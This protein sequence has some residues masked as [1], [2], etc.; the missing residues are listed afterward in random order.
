MSKLL[1]SI[2]RKSMG[3]MAIRVGFYVNTELNFSLFLT[4]SFQMIS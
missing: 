1:F 3:I 2:Q 4:K